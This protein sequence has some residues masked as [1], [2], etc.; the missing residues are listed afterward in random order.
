MPYAGSYKTFPHSMEWFYIPWSALQTDYSTF[1]WTEMDRRLNEIAAR[2]HQA[3]FRVYLD[4]PGSAYGVPSFLAHVPKQ[5]Y[6]GS[7]PSFS[8]DYNNPDLQR[9]LLN[10]IAAFGARYD[11][12]PRVGFITAGLLGFW[13]E[14]HTYPYNWM[15]PAA[16]KTQVLD[17][18]ERAFP[19]TIIL[20]RSPQSGV[21]MDRPR[22]GFHDDSFAYTTIGSTSWYFWPS[23][24]AAGLGQ[25]WRTR[26]IGGEVRPEVQGCIWNDPTCTPAGQSFDLSVTTT[27]ASWMLNQGTFTGALSP[28][29]QARAMAGAR[30]MGYTLY[31]PT[32][33]LEPAQVSSALRG[34]VTV[35]NRGVA[36]FFYP[37][38]VLLGVLDGQGKLRTWPMTWDLRTA[39]SNATTTWSF[40]VAGHGLAA[41]SYTLLMG[42]PNPMANGRPLRFANSAQDQN[43]AGWLSLGVFT[44]RP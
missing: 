42:V 21:N 19:R 20:A 14:W 30:S 38:P 36:S 34:T 9:A 39:L 26:P 10:F 35:E 25:I 29:Q 3:V 8:P 12:D 44:I 22:L 33:T 40:D 31:V 4:Y 6:S 7:G 24:Q 2:G 23:L 43:L 1:S 5:S 15:P 41:G 28:A 13:G 37:W 16:F 11:G 17:A 27:H 18:F 32:A